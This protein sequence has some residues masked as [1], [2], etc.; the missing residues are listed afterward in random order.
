[1]QTHIF[2]RQTG[3][4]DIASAQRVLLYIL[5]SSRLAS[6]LSAPSLHCQ[7]F[8]ENKGILEMKFHLENPPQR[9]VSLER[10]KQLR[11]QSMSNL[12]GTPTDSE[13]T[14]T[15]PKTCPS[16]LPTHWP[17]TNEP[18]E[19]V[20]GDLVSELCV[21]E[22]ERSQLE[23]SSSHGLAPN[24]ATLATVD[25]NVPFTPSFLSDDGDWS[26]T[27]SGCS[28]ERSL[29]RDGSI[30]SLFRQSIPHDVMSS[31]G[32]PVLSRPTSPFASS[33]CTKSE[34]FFGVELQWKGIK[35]ATT[36]RVSTS[37][38][39]YSMKSVS[40]RRQQLSLKRKA[41]QGAMKRQ[42]RAGVRCLPPVPQQ[43]QPAE[44]PPSSVMTTMTTTTTT[45]WTQPQPTTFAGGPTNSASPVSSP[46]HRPFPAIPIPPR[47][48]SRPLPPRPVPSAST[49]VSPAPVAPLQPR[50]L[51]LPGFNCQSLEPPSVSPIV[52]MVNGMLLESRSG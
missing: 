29:Q 39:V 28:Y 6:S 21:P 17:S 46:S 23:P 31:L 9:T 11:R 35:N 2:W 37:T 47:S 44:L 25:I 52:G 20:P 45:V 40:L 10:S 16:V 50:R 19:I 49:T 22:V 30:S 5:S 34:E 38:T 4:G 14:G 36:S 33:L 15:T 18:T 24:R 43:E 1:M 42:Q 7:H 12:P 13:A 41:H 27:F 48:K 51:L 26:I 8:G 3:I 32:S